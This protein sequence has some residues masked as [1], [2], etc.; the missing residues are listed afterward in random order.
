MWIRVKQ[1][2]Y[3]I[4]AFNMHKPSKQNMCEMWVTKAD[5]KTLCVATSTDE[6]KIATINEM[7][8][9]ATEQKLPFVDLVEY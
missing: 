8:N 2:T 3:K 7:L 1:G 4:I 6:S 5:G 9:F